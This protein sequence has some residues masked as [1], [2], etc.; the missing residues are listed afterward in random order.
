MFLMIQRFMDVIYDLE[1]SH[2]FRIK[3]PLIPGDNSSEI[4]KD[5]LDDDLFYFCHSLHD[6]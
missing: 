6:L 3:Q 5:I 1:L 2:R 4:Q